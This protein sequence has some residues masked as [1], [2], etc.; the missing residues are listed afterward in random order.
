MNATRRMASLGVLIAL[1]LCYLNAAPLVAQD[2]G[3]KAQPYT[4]AEYNAYTAAANEQNAATQI[5]ELDDFVA[6]YPSSSL[7][8][9]V[10][11]LY[12]QNYAKQK[13]FP[14]VMEYVDKELA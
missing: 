12:F 9:Y 1:C 10:Y 11:P 6:K 3:A 4:M 7:L 14:K 8:N 13:N 5:K 2:A